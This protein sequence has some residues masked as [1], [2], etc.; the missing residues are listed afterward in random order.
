MTID[1]GTERMRQE[2]GHDCIVCPG[3]VRNLM[4]TVHNL[5]VKLDASDWSG[6]FRKRE[7]VRE[8]LDKLKPISEQH[9][10]ALDDGRRP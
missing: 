10:K 1:P 8:A 4:A 9:F 6:V 2:T 3:D 5:L 7:A